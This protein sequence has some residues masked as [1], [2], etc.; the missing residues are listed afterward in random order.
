MINQL[1]EGGTGPDAPAQAGAQ[2]PAALPCLNR[3]NCTK[4]AG[5][6]LT[7]HGKKTA[8]A[9]IQNIALLAEKHGIERIIFGTLTFKDPLPGEKD[10][11]RDFKEASKRF[12]SLA[13][14]ILKGLFIEWITVPERGGK[15]GRLHFHLLGVVKDDVR[16]GVDFEAFGR[17]DYSSAPWPLKRLWAIFRD[18]RGQGK[19]SAY[20]FGRTEWMPIKSTTEGISKYTGKYIA[21]QFEGRRPEDKGMRLVRYTQGANN[22][23]ARFSWWSPRSRLWR[24]LLS[25]FAAEN[26]VCDLDGMREKFGTR[27]AF[28][29]RERIMARDLK[30]EGESDYALHE[31]QQFD[32][33]VLAQ[34]VARTAG[35]SEDRAYMM[36]FDG[37]K[38]MFAGSDRIGEDDEKIMVRAGEM[39]AY[40]SD[41][42]DHNGA[43]P[44]D[45]F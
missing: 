13:T 20:G 33:I 2:A 25:Q 28:K 12:H 23:R 37:E 18:K 3:N 40:R 19:A 35:M 5:K 39:F 14:H 42:V 29:L 21:K 27:W 34:I 15:G 1:G 32:R 11:N 30:V 22:Y 9:L 6:R 16:T 10:P 8:F 31:V 17:G 38:A 45:P 24:R 41:D 44:D 26:G 43:H 7:P 36:L 4:E